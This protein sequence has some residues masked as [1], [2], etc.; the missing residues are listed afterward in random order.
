MPR[1]H[2]H[3]YLSLSIYGKSVLV[4]YN[5]CKFLTWVLYVLIDALVIDTLR[6]SQIAKEKKK[7][8]KHDENMNTASFLFGFFT[9]VMKGARACG[10]PGVFSEM[11]FSH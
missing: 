7:Q 2:A 3:I 5:C 1:V 6:F 9:S 11:L 10:G 4:L 8:I